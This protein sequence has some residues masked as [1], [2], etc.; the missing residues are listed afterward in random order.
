MSATADRNTGASILVRGNTQHQIFETG[1]FIFNIS[2]TLEKLYRRKFDPAT[3][4]VIEN[5]VFKQVRSSDPEFKHLQGIIPKIKSGT[6]T[7]FNGKSYR[8]YEL[9]SQKKVHGYK[10]STTVS[11]G[12]QVKWKSMYFVFE[13]YK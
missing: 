5:V 8:V 4:E 6:S 11:D 9:I 3:N 7:P 13:K 2:S 12:H 1:R 10:L